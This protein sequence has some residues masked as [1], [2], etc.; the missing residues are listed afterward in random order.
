MTAVVIVFLDHPLG[1]NWNYKMALKGLQIVEL[2]GLA[3]APMCG[4]I[5]SDFGANVIRVDK[6]MAING[7][8]FIRYDILTSFIFAVERPVF[9]RY[10]MSRKE[11]DSYKFKEWKGRPGF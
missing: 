9:T 3:P 2:A 7:K 11:I 4:M 8:D 5:L 10:F 6:V 1:D